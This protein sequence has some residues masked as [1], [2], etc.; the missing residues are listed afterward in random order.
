MDAAQR[1]VV[2][3]DDRARADPLSRVE[4]T[5][6]TRSRRTGGR[7]PTAARPRPPGPGRPRA[8]PGRRPRPPGTARV[9]AGRPP[10]SPGSGSER[11]AARRRP[12]R[13]AVRRRRSGGGAR[14]LPGRVPHGRPPPGPHP[15]RPPVPRRAATSRTQPARNFWP[16]RTSPPPGTATTIQRRRAATERGRAHDREHQTEDAGCDEAGAAGPGQQRRAPATGRSHHGASTTT[17]AGGTTAPAGRR[18]A[19][20]IP[21][22]V[23][24]L[25]ATPRP[26]SAP[27]ANA[28][29]P[30]GSLASPPPRSTAGRI[31]GRLT[32]GH[33]GQV[34]RREP[35]PPAPGAGSARG[36]DAQDDGGASRANGVAAAGRGGDRPRTGRG[37]RAGRRG[38]AAAAA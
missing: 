9:P 25:P 17:R 4:L 13:R 1:Q 37:Q 30:A 16:S 18:R 2:G 36:E 21:P 35:H 15:C 29:T 14:R 7:R 3:L 31:H 19:F 38:R 34:T 32:S 33:E 22:S 26:L 20:Q 8:R 5:R 27:D 10:P 6:R 28:F 24:R 23:T 12:R 11:R